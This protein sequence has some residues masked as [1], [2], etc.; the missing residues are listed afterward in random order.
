MS[1]KPQIKI[2]KRN[3]QPVKVVRSAEIEARTARTAA[4]EMVSNV[5]GWVTEFQHKRRE[6]TKDAFNKLFAAPDGCANC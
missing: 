3:A 2:I 1:T 6:D 4:R 5:S